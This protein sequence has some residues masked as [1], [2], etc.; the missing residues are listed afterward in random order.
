MT[1]KTILEQINKIEKLRKYIETRRSCEISALNDNYDITIDEVNDD[2]YP[3]DM[4]DETRYISNY[5]AGKAQALKE[6]LAEID[7]Q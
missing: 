6:I 3:D 2:D 5:M 1:W 4:D 7:K